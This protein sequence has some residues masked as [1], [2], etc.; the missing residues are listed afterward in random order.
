MTT[1]GLSRGDIRML[2]AK[3]KYNMKQV[4]KLKDS[5][6]NI[7]KI[8]KLENNIKQ[9]EKEIKLLENLS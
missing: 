5:N 1:D 9:Y 2:K 4:K 7:D 6:G 8:H 3:I